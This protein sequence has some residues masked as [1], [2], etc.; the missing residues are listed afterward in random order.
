MFGREVSELRQDQASLFSLEQHPSEIALRDRREPVERLCGE[1]FEVAVRL[2]QFSAMVAI[3]VAVID[4]GYGFEGVGRPLGSFQFA[5]RSFLTRPLAKPRDTPL[6]PGENDLLNVSWKY[7]INRFRST[8]LGAIPSPLPSHY[9][10]GFDEQKIE[11]DALQ[12]F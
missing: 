2:A 1:V 3:S 9:L 7:R 5:S 10:L 8:W 12:V 6:M 11:A 4:A